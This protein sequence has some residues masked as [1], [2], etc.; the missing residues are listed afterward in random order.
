M[1]HVVLLAVRVWRALRDER[2]LRA[3]GGC[4]WLRWSSL[5]IVLGCGTWVT[6]YGWPGWL[7]G[8]RLGRRAY[9]DAPRA[10][11]QALITTAHVA[12]GSLILA[13][14]LVLVLR[15][16]RAVRPAA[17]RGW[18]SASL[19]LRWRRPDEHASALASLRPPSAGRG[20]LD[21]PIIVELTK[22]RIAVL[23]LVTVAVGGVCG[24]LGPAR[25]AGCCCTRWWA[26]R[27]WPPAPARSINGSSATPT[28]A[29]RARPIGRCRPAGLPAAKSSRFG[30]AHARR[31]A[32]VYLAWR[33]E[34][35]DGRAGLSTLGR[36]RVRSTRRSRRARRSTRPSAPWPG[37]MPVLM[38]WTAVG[39]AARPARPGAV[40]DRVPLAVSALHGDRL[41][42]SPRVRRRRALQ[43]LTVVDPTGLRAGAQAVVAA[44]VLMPVSL[45]PA[46]CRRPAAAGVLRLGLGAWAGA[47]APARS[48]SALRPR[49]AV[50][51]AA[52]A[53]RRW[54]ICRRCWAC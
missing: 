44:L 27:W 24:R 50:G 21:W 23:V 17:R 47:V 45:V 6:K 54:F 32:S 31:R 18:H 14:S 53:W 11:L 51:P 39:R 52:V 16:A 13:V 30:A 4:A 5:Q 29:C 7:S 46:C 37:R 8:L 1:V 26:R 25:R 40:P 35:A 15:C 22:P 49:R 9:V 2:W 42:L 34:L 48:V 10:A 36:L 41:D 12:I 3:A 19:R 20:R 28:P 38:G 33:V 43:M